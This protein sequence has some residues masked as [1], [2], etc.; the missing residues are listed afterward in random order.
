VLGTYVGAWIERMREVFLRVR[1]SHVLE[2]GLLQ[3]IHAHLGPAARRAFLDFRLTVPNP[4]PPLAP[5]LEIAVFRIVQEL[6]SNTVRHAD[7]RMLSVSIHFDAPWILIEAKDDGRGFDV[8]S[9]LR[10]ARDGS[11]LGLLGITER[12]RALGGD[13]VVLSAPRS[14]TTVRA[15]LRMQ[16]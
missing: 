2:I 13:A 15:R 4:V 1:V 14:G 7:A 16:G 12:A 5:E 6:V 10:T 9:I 11:Q 8:P 3:A